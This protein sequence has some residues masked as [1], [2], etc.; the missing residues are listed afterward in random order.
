MKKI[1]FL[2]A[3]VASLLLV[4]PVLA[5]DYYVHPDGEQTEASNC[6]KEPKPNWPLFKILDSTCEIQSVLSDSNVVAGDRINFWPATYTYD[7]DPVPPALSDLPIIL[8]KNLRL[9][10]GGEAIIDGTGYS[11]SSGLIQINHLS[12]ADLIR[13]KGFT[14]KANGTAGTPAIFTWNTSSEVII[15]KNIFNIASLES[16]AYGIR[17]NGSENVKIFNNL[18]FGNADSYLGTRAIFIQNPTSGDPITISVYNNTFSFCKYGMILQVS[19]QDAIKVVNNI[20]TN[21][22]GGIVTGGVPY[23]TCAENTK[24]LSHQDNLFYG[25]G[26]EIRGT[27]ADCV[28]GAGEFIADPLYVDGYPVGNPTWDYVRNVT[29]DD[30]DFHVQTGSPSL[31]EGQDFST[32]GVTV[33]LDGIARPQNVL[34][35]I[36]CYEKP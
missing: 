26:Y 7:P 32:E 2:V 10:G 31:E 35:D 18:F 13:V 17:V 14:I 24:Y 27:D 29:I 12:G 1:S 22:V 8:N 16:N 6:N 11:N 15:E 23:G 20:F 19:E 28:L 36:G 4:Q 34:F 33:D 30:Y 3:A 5:A 9:I 21:N 25:N